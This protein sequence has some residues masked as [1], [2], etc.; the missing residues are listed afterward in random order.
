MKAIVRKPSAIYTS[1]LIIFDLIREK[2]HSNVN[3]IAVK[4]IL[5]LVTEINIIFRVKIRKDKIY[6]TAE[7]NDH[8]NL[9]LF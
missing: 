3:T 6:S 7:N 4:N 1:Y 2:D 8:E 5:R 9:K